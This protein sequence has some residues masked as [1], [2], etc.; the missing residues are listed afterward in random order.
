MAVVY[1]RFNPHYYEVDGVLFDP[2]LEAR[3]EQL[4][5]VLESVRMRTLQL[6]NATGLNVVYLYY[7]QLNGEVESLTA[8]SELLPLLDLLSD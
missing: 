6:R 2:P 5:Q 1:V 7:P 3:Y 4:A 8:E